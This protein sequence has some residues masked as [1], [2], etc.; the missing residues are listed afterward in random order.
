MP[1]SQTQFTV[2]QLNTQ[3][4]H[5]LESSLSNIWVRGEISNFHHHPAS[6]HMY[7]TLKDDKSELHCTM[8]RRNNQFL[9]FKPNGGMEVRV[10]GM[11]TLYEK[12][13]QVQVKVLKMEP[14]GIGDLF[15]AFELLKGTLAKEG[16]FNTEYKKPI[17]TYPKCIGLITSASS[18]A[19]K[20][21]IHILERRAP[22]VRIIIR[23]TKVQGNGSA[24][25]IAIAIDEFNK[26]GQVDTLIVGR[27]GGSLEDLWAFNEEIVARKIF[28]SKIP[29]ISAVGHETDF[30]I[31]DLVAD[32]R[33]PT[34]SAAAE[35]VSISSN[36]ILTYCLELKNTIS[37]NLQGKMD[38]YFLRM[39]HLIDR[40]LLQQPQKII[41]RQIEKLNQ[42]RS[43]L[44]HSEQVHLTQTKD[45]LTFLRKQI[46]A[47]DPTQVL[48]RGY[49]IAFDS[50]R[51]IIRSAIDIEIGDSF[52]LKTSRGSFGAK[53]IDDI[54]KT[55]NM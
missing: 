11:V 12:R 48:D 53:K 44:I 42:F 14:A 8:F 43:R 26:Y 34:P 25:D 27:G 51:N 29:I 35:L 20:D 7:F 16:L 33:A 38:Q 6:G 52:E 15:K 19:F 2:S 47:L 3:I 40:V 28:E 21:I 18:A 49:T 24:N 23:S 10:N 30:T 36:D 31:S 1:E 41:V 50:S 54:H 46:S 39:D 5:S 9:N 17:Q 13:G 4:R 22:H 55:E 37:K 45:S 32:I